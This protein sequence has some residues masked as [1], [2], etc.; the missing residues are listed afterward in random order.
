LITV[1]T[2]LIAAILVLTPAGTLAENKITIIYLGQIMELNSGKVKDIPIIAYH[3]INN[4]ISGYEDMFVPVEQFQAR[5]EYLHDFVFTPITF[6]E[7][8][9]FLH[10]IVASAFLSL[11]I[12]L[13][14]VNNSSRK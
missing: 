7:L 5:M 9:F 12:Q 1:L 14:R 6:S 10:V 2:L 8:A 4:T 3:C 11:P 13:R